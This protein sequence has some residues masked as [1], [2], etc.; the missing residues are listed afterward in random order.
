[1]TSVWLSSVGVLGPGLNG[2]DQTREVLQG[3][4]PYR[5]EHVPIPAPEILPPRDRRR[6][7]DTVSLALHVAL[8]TARASGLDAKTLPSVFAYSSGDGQVIHRLLT[9]LAKSNKAVSPTD[10]HNSV[11]NA[12]AFYW[13]LGTGCQ[14]AST[15]IAAGRYTFA[16]AFLK[17]VV[18]S[19]ARGGPVLM[20]CFD[21]P[22][23]EPLAA[24]YPISAPFGVGLVLT[25][26]PE[27]TPVAKLNTEWTAR[28][29]SFAAADRPR[30]G[31]LLDLWAGNPAARSIPLLEV[32]A[33]RRG[34]TICLSG[35]HDAILRVGVTCL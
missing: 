32:I 33:N 11:H 23:L 14:E 12:A 31:A 20:V 3:K 26:R 9:G 6:C 5:A 7:S 8:E 28:D 29:D 22:L 21:H 30:N 10:F 4:R 18:E 35:S 2:W 19:S 27:G 15:S 16:A 13:S 24:T 1:M 17:A 25:P 34:S